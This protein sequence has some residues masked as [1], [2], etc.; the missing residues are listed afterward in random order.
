MQIYLGSRDGTV[1]R[2]L[3][4]HKCRQFQFWPSAII[5]CLEFVVGSCFAPR[6]FL[7]AFRVSSLHKNKHIQIEQGPFLERPGNFL[8]MLAKSWTLQLQSCSF[9]TH[10][11]NM[12]RGSLYTRSFRRIHFSVFR[13]RWTKNGFTGPKSFRDFWETGPRIENLHE[14]SYGWCGFLSK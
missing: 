2:R 9:W 6:V 7:W 11:L 10:I 3:T 12:N 8:G 13:Y 1:V 5:M 14:I 4:Y